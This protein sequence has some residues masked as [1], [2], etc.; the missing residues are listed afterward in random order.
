MSTTTLSF[1]E[2]VLPINFAGI[3]KLIP[4]RSP[5]LLIEEIREANLEEGTIVA[6]KGLPA[7][8]N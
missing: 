6:T 1:G 7:R 4:H 2:L 8:A 5:I 3:K